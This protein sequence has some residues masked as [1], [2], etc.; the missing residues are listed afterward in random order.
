VTFPSA[1]GGG[2]EINATLV[3]EDR[4]HDLAVLKVTTSLP[5]L[6]LADKEPGKG[7]KVVVIGSPAV[8]GTGIA[9]ENSVTDGIFSARLKVPDYP[10]F[11]QITAPLNPGNSGGPV[12]NTQGQVLGVAKAVVKDKQGMNLAIPWS[13][14]ARALKAVNSQEEKDQ[15][16]AA[17]EHDGVVVFRAHAQAAFLVNQGLFEYS[18][19]LL[20]AAKK[21][22]DPNEALRQA[23]TKIAQ[24][25]L[26]RNQAFLA[27]VQALKNRTV[28]NLP[29]EARKHLSDLCDL[30]A[31]LEDLFL[32]PRGSTASPFESRV[33]DLDE[34]RVRVVQSLLRDF[35]MDNLDE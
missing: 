7:D 28:K 34:K 1:E 33:K 29:E 14:V 6:A 35:G 8:T 31:E 17:T 15:E 5:S 22:G 20:E 21:S 3:Y 16:Q 2:G 4:K 32:R 9:A 12:F 11:Y 19:A 24:G 27:P 10:E 18:K 23:Q 26:N 30:H 25:V 13:D